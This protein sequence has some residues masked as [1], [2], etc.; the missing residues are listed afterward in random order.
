MTFGAREARPKETRMNSVK[1]E[2]IRLFKDDADVR[3]AVL[4]ALSADISG[5]A[6]LMRRAHETYPL[7][8][9]D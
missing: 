3:R 1:A 6:Q 5:F 2:L 9:R 7:K 8:L 4:E